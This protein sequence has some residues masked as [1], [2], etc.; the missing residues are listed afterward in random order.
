MDSDSD[1][2]ILLS[3]SNE[4]KDIQKRFLKSC[5]TDPPPTVTK[6]KFEKFW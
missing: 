5:G 3:G 2:V 6:V 4:Y 1:M